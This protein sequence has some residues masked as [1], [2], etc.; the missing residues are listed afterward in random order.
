[1][2]SHKFSTYV[3]FLVIFMFENLFD[4]NAESF[5]LYLS[6]IKRVKKSRR[7]GNPFNSLHKRSKPV[8]RVLNLIFTKLNEITSLN[9]KLVFTR[10]MSQACFIYAINFKQVTHYFTCTK[11]SIFQK[12]ADLSILWI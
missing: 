7:H 5:R 3:P 11:A 4:E 8:F 2:Q 1:M 12:C 10:M 9:S 6:A